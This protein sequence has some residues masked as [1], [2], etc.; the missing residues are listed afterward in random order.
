MK[1]I[2]VIVVT[3][4]SLSLTRAKAQAPPTPDEVA[5]AL[6]FTASK[7]A[8]IKGGAIVSKDLKEGS[9]KE[10][11]CVVAVLFKPPVS[12]LVDVAMQGKMLETDITI[13]AFPLLKPDASADSAL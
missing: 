5:K 1:H 12:E 11:A 7:I 10:L 4:L 6:G 3:V 13:H 2:A 8:Q 9:D